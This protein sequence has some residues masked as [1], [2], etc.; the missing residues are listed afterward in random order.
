M[1]T[2]DAL[3]SSRP[4]GKDQREGRPLGRDQFRIYRRQLRSDTRP[5]AD[6]INHI[7][8][9]RHRTNQDNDTLHKVRPT[10]GEESANKTIKTD[11]RRR[12]QDRLD[13]S[14]TKKRHHRF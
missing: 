11:D 8:A 6:V 10:D 3:K 12:Y 9:E 4:V 2:S 7:E 1:R 5:T 13:I 14:Q